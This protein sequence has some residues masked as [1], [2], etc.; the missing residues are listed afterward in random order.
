MVKAFHLHIWG[1]PLAR[2]VIFVDHL[3]ALSFTPLSNL[4]CRQL[5]TEA[6]PSVFPGIE[7][8]I[9]RTSSVVLPGGS[10][11]SK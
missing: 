4:L 5:L 2:K 3:L 1:S 8:A 10:W 7:C 6:R 11:K 9:N